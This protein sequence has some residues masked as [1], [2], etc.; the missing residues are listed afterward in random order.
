[1]SKNQLQNIQN[2]V[3]ELG[4]ALKLSN[5]LTDSQKLEITKQI[6]QIL[7]NLYV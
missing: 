6:L 7:N 2:Q 3:K 5:S 4:L 1:M